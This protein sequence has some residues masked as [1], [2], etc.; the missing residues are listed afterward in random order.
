MRKQSGQGELLRL[1]FLS[2]VVLT[3]KGATHLEILCILNLIQVHNN[4]RN[5]DWFFFLLLFVV[6]VVF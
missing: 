5:S 4:H 6:V 2:P 3:P 1:L